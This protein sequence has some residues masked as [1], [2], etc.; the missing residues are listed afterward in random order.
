MPAIRSA[1]IVTAATTAVVALAVLVPGCGSEPAEFDK[2][3]NYSPD[4]LAQELILRYR[5]L[6]PD[7]K[8]SKRGPSKGLSK[9]AIAARN[10]A[11]TKVREKGT[12]KKQAAPEIDDVLDD[13]KY[14]M[15]LIPG[16]TPAETSKKMVETISGDNS[17]SE[18][19]K[20]ALT[21]FVDRLTE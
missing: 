12:T 1:I 15:T 11:D 14:K 16:T 8:N 19:D 9:Q 13:I 18:S 3:A 21:E 6:N 10:K 20:K 5:A 2:A 4:S 7:A 17:L